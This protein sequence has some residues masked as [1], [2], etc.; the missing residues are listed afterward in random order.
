M[1]AQP[2]QA[3]LH[4]PGGHQRVALPPH[5]E[6]NFDGVAGALELEAALDVEPPAPGLGVGLE[7]A[8]LERPEADLGM[9]LDVQHL[10]PP[11]L[12]LDLR[13]V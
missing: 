13:D 2:A 11:H 8:D 6:G 4:L 5:F 1:D 12:L 3:Q 10:G 7:G 9:A